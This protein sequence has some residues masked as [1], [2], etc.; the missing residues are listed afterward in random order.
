MVAPRDADADRT[1]LASAH[2]EP[3]TD[4]VAESPIWVPPAPGHL[5]LQYAAAGP[6]LEQPALPP[7]IILLEPV[8]S[9]PVDVLASVDAPK[10]PV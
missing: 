9:G 1:L 7:A 8:A 5:P 10:P 4:P 2:T 3:D 6:L